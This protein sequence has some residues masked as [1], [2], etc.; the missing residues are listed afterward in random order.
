MKMKSKQQNILFGVLL[1]I[2]FPLLGKASAY[3]MEISG[4]HKIGG[5]VTVQLIYGNIDELGVRHRQT[6]KELLLAAEFSFK[7]IDPVGK[8]TL[9][10]FVQK[11]DCWQATFNP[12]NKGVYRILGIN[13][14]HPV[15]DRSATGG[16]NVLPIDYLCGQYWVG[17]P[18]GKLE[19]AQ[20]L[21][22]FSKT[23]GNVVKIFAFKDNLP[24]KAKTKLRVFNPE[25]WERELVLDDKGEA[26]FLPTMKGMYVI[27][28]DWVDPK[29][30]TYKGTAYTSIRHRCNYCLFVE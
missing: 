5:R 29:E 18:K 7:L 3:W 13:K 20:F 22:L 1:L 11:S 8:I 6:G 15:I 21:D 28:L 12:K 25:N 27:R 10:H 2:F 23:E 24:A 16:E 17:L 26:F 30:G 4:G 9:L 14:T 19:P